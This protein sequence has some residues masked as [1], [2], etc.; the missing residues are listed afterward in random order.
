MRQDSVKESSVN[1]HS[2][3]NQPLGGM[4][5]PLPDSETTLCSP[6]RCSLIRNFITI[7]VTNGLVSEYQNTLGYIANLTTRRVG[8]RVCKSKSSAAALPPSTFEQCGPI[9]QCDEQFPNHFAGGFVDELSLG[10]ETVL[11][12]GDHHLGF[13]HELQVHKYPDLAEVILRARCANGESGFPLAPTS[14]Y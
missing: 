13:V 12:C 2:G 7:P 11:G 14:R 9:R 1:H 8:E 5:G 6:R 10:V 3:C 4:S